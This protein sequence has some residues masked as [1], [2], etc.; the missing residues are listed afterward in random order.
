MRQALAMLPPKQR[1]VLVLRHYVGEDDAAIAEALNC[2]TGAVRVSASRGAA[3]L[4]AVLNE[5]T[6][7]LTIAEGE[8]K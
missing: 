7:R 1:A 6:A 4:R 3:K 5:D 8:K 2:T